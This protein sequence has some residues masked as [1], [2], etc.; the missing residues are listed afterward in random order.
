M[1]TAKGSGRARVGRAVRGLGAALLAASVLSG[2]FVAAVA[3]VAAPAG[4]SGVYWPAAGT[5]GF[6][7]NGHGCSGTSFAS[8]AAPSGV[9]NASH[10]G[11]DFVQ[12]NGWG[13][14][15][16]SADDPCF[17]AQV[18]WYQQNDAGN[19][20]QFVMFPVPY[21]NNYCSSYS[22]STT[23]GHNAGWG[24]AQMIYDQAQSAGLPVAGGT[25]WLDVEQTTDCN[26]WNTSSSEWAVNISVL[27]GAVDYFHSLGLT[28]GLYTDPYDWSIITGN[29]KSTFAGD[30]AWNADLYNGSHVTI[31]NNAQQNPYDWSS[32]LSFAQSACGAAGITG[33]PQWAVQ[34]M[35]GNYSNSSFTTNQSPAILGRD[36]DYTCKGPFGTLGPPSISSISGSG[37]MASTMTLSGANFGSSQGSSYVH[38]WYTA[39]NPNSCSADST[40]ISWGAPGNSAA[41]S[42]VSWSNGSVGFQVPTPSGPSRQG[43]TWMIPAG[44]TGCVTVVTS[45]GTSN[46]VSFIAGGPATASYVTNGWSVAFQG[47]GPFSGPSNNFPPGQSVALVCSYDSGYSIL[48]QQGY[49]YP[50]WDL[51]DSGGNFYWVWDGPLSTPSGGLSQHCSAYP[52]GNT[53]PAALNLMVAMSGFQI[54]QPTDVFGAGFGSSQGSGYVHL[55]SNGTPGSSSVNCGNGST[56]S[57]N[58]GEPGNAAAFTLDGW[59]DTRVVFQTPTPSGPGQAGTQWQIPAG[60]W[61]CVN[62]YNSAG[63]VD[64]AAQA[65]PFVA[66]APVTQTWQTTGAANIRSGPSTNDAVEW[67]ASS[68]QSL[69]LICW[70]P[71]GQVVSG[72][73]TWDQLSTGAWVWDGLMNTPSGGPSG[74]PH[75]SD[76]PPML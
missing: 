24:E 64:W 49:Q 61:A 66:G 60:D 14:A 19:P 25:W 48:D 10:L 27:Q 5:W 52:S 53:A 42:V 45:S 43:Q 35:W 67:T 41:F 2:I 29:N 31:Y 28:A 4:A 71:S 55:W 70:D 33:G 51:V 17:Q 23:D 54:G 59:A 26:G 39:D 37:A 47:P 22:T 7:M 8:G 20:I 57:T 32:V 75:C 58:W 3:S 15:G 74:L 36:F 13:W 68:G 18:N 30:P 69:T 62:I 46:T 34:Y 44:D 72:Y 73:G 11:L 76:Y 40:T 65:L 50:V 21:D 16:M 63:Q 56:T 9:T 1:G 38:L 6:D 12:L